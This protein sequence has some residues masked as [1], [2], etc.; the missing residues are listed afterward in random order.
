MNS[1]ENLFTPA[2]V[3]IRHNAAVLQKQK[4]YLSQL[5]ALGMRDADVPYRI[6]QSI[7]DAHRLFSKPGQYVRMGMAATKQ[8]DAPPSTKSIDTIFNLLWRDPTTFSDRAVWLFFMSMLEAQTTFARQA[9]K[10]PSREETLS[11][12]LLAF[13]N[14]SCESWK[15]IG[16]DLLFETGDTL[17]LG[18]IDLQVGGGEQRTGG[19]FAV[20]LEFGFPNNSVF[21]PLIFQAKRYEGTSADVSQWNNKRG[22]QRD[23]MTQQKC[24]TAYV[25]YENGKSR[26][27]SPAVPLVKD[28]STV[29]RH[30]ELTTNPLTD[31]TDLAT[32][33][34][35]SIDRALEKPVANSATEAFS[36]ILGSPDRD[37]LQYLV[38]ISSS[39]GVKKRYDDAYAALVTAQEAPTRDDDDDQYDPPRPW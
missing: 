7:Y 19:D 22:Y 33:V 20:V 16:D 23:V 29:S 14:S 9:C 39:A 3:E 1:Y 18:S 17:E 21:L 34:M 4:L 6:A 2:L 15:S 37:R 27:E 11:G 10:A 38:V 25:F 13:L 35:V 32:Y 36:L 12:A 30:S 5:H 26:I 24:P 28:V 31:S 8:T